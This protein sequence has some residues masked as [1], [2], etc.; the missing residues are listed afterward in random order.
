MTESAKIEAIEKKYENIAGVDLPIFEGVIFAPFT[1]PLFSTPPWLEGVVAD[2][3][4][5]AI[6][7]ARVLVAEEKKTALEKELREVSIRVNLFEKNLIPKALQNIKRI[8]VFLGDQQL[9]AVGQAKAAKSKILQR[10][11]KNRSING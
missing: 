9:A 4:K 8:K 10:K 2:L 1:Y 6:S 3:R 5:L 11:K 7:R